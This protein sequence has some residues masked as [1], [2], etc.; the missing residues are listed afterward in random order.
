[1]HSRLARGA[2]RRRRLLEKI[3]LL[4]HC[5][6]GLQAIA[7]PFCA[8]V[9]E[10]IDADAGL[11][12]WIGDD[13]QPSGFYHETAPP[14]LKDLFVTRFDDL[15]NDGEEISAH[16]LVCG[17]GPEI[18]KMLAPGMQETFERGNIYHHLCVPINHRYMLDMSSRGKGAFFAFNAPNRPFTQLH[19]EALAPVAPLMA[20]A[21]DER[22]D[23]SQWCRLGTSSAHLVASLDGHELLAID[24]EAERLLCNSHLLRQNLPMLAQPRTAPGFVMILAS[25]IGQLQPAEMSMPVPDGRLHCSAKRMHVLPGDGRDRQEVLMVDL[26]LQFAKEV[27]LIEFLFGRSLTALQRKIAYDALLGHSRTDCR[28]RLGLSAES[29]KKHLRTNFLEH[30]VDNWEALSRLSAT[31]VADHAAAIV[32]RWH[33]AMDRRL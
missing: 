17:E 26:E 4:C 28:E 14:E 16:G 29:F 31:I 10:L 30:G 6:A 21:L 3:A 27:A 2:I 1:M 15:F 23:S 24:E 19:A 32:R 20:I 5:G 9:R 11:L 12:I 25:L 7:S 18:G 13:G 8:A 33:V 22:S